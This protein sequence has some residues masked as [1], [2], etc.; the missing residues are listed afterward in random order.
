MPFSVTQ[1]ND[2]SVP[3]KARTYTE[4]EVRDAVAN[5]YQRCADSL[6]NYMRDCDDILRIEDWANSTRN[7]T[8][9]L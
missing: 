9:P 2:F 5:A 1:R 4:S 3:A 8:E 7:G 6:V